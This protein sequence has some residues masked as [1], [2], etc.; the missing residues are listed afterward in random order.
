MQLAVEDW[1][2]CLIP[3]LTGKARSAYVHMDV[4]D[5]L[6]YDKVKCAIFKKYNHETYRPRFRSLHVEPEGPPKELYVRF[7]ELYAKWIQM[8]DKTVNDIG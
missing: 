4:D 3:L 1:G 8:K 5:S 6:D 7:K 2:F